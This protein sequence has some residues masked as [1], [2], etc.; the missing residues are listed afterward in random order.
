MT[1]FS[2]N[3][4]NICFDPLSVL[5]IFSF[6]ENLWHKE[7]DFTS[8]QRNFANYLHKTRQ[9]KFLQTFLLYNWILQMNKKLCKVEH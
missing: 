9:K 2:C 4:L 5:I 3:K 1:T 8:F 7:T 6:L